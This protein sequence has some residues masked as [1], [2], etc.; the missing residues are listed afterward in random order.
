MSEERSCSVLQATEQTLTFIQNNNNLQD[1][2]GGSKMS[3]WE[4]VSVILVRDDGDMEQHGSEEVGKQFSYLGYILKR[5]LTRV[6]D[7]MTRNG[8][9]RNLTINNHHTDHTLGQVY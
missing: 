4:A 3:M 1:I 7:G 2:K 6:V 5:K 8:S 9:E